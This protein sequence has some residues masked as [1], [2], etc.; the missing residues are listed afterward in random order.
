VPAFNPHKFRHTW[1]N[2][3]LA[4]GAD[5]GDVMRLAGWESR[6]M[7]DRYTAYHAQER[8]LVNYRDPLDSLIQ[9]GR[10]GR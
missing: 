8:A 2:A 9:G 5:G 4:N 7:L 1:A 10:R 6:Q 3:M